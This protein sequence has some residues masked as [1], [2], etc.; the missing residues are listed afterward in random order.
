MHRLSELPDFERRPP[1]DD[2]VRA[3]VDACRPD[4]PVRPGML[5]NP[6]AATNWRSVAHDRLARRM[7]DPAACVSTPSLADLP[8]GLGYLLFQRRCNVLV[9]NGG[10]G[11]I[12]HAVNATLEVVEQASQ[13]LGAPVPLPSFLFV[14]G[15]GM[16]MLARTF[17]TRGHPVR[18]L[19]R[20]LATSRD[21]PLAQLVTRWVPL[22]SV[23]EPSGR[24]RHGFI[25]GSELVLNALTM[26]ERFGQ[27]YRGLT[28]FFY[29]VAAGIT[30]QTEL[31]RRYGHLLDAPDTPLVVDDIVH[32][33]YTAAV[34]TTVPML[35]LKGL[36]GTIRRTAPPGRLN[37]VAVLETDKA[38]V[39]GTIPRL[40]VGAPHPGVLYGEARRLRLHGPYTLDGERLTRLE[41]DPDDP[42]SDVIE[43]G[44]TQRVIRGVCVT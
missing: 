24:L 21:T 5:S 6:M 10:D 30:L 38:R 19:D 22:L 37:T 44:G 7:P 1:R 15:G 26:Y 31:Y 29:E 17:D 40:L 35:L 18:T 43:V 25:F 2:E 36:V 3:Y 14:N 41:A 11:T 28:R 34:A 8:W 12:H 39:V 32:P 27:G 33:R 16:N 20:F 9:I 23:R 42:A 13:R 4:A